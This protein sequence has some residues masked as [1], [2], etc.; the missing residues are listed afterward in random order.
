MHFVSKIILTYCEKK[1]VLVIEK[2]LENEGE[3]LQKN[4]LQLR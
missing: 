2:T 3:K 1:N 4:F